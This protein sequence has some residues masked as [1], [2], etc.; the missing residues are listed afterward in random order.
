[1]KK[2]LLRIPDELAEKLKQ[3]AKEDGR[4]VN[5]YLNHV[6]TQLEKQK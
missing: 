5:G 3:S 1:M 4:S 6:L 2:I